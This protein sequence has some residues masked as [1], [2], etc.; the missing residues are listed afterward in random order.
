MKKI[1]FVVLLMASVFAQADDDAKRKQLNELLELMN[2]SSIVDNMYSQ[3]EPQL[4]SM[5]TQLGVKP[6]EQ[7]I[8]DKYYG[9]M[10]QL[11][12][13]ELSWKKMEPMILDVYSRNF[14]E[15][16]IDDMLAFYRTETG[17]SVIKKLPAVMQESMQIS[18]QLLQPVLPKIQKISQEL[19]AE[20]ETARKPK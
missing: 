17:K 20:L 16:E 5:S 11:M 1:I 10:I 18:N 4:K 3:L 12:K 8:F 15:K 19:S 13:D 9:K 7:P 6:S 14:T 2:M